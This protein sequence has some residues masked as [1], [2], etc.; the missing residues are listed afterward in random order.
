MRPATR[1]RSRKWIGSLLARAAWLAACVASTTLRAQTLPGRLSGAGIVVGLEYSLLDN[2]RLSNSLADAF[3]VTGLTGMKH[4]VESVQ[5]G[6]MQKNATAPIDFSKL[7]WFVRGYQSRGFTELTI[8]LKPHSEWASKSVGKLKSTNAAP[9]PE[10][11][12]LFQT[13]VAAV[14]E[15]YDHDGVNDMNGL[16]W[17]VRLVEIGN[18]FSSY[19]PEPADEYLDVLRMAYQAAHRASSTVLVGHAAFLTTP[20]NLDVSDPLEYD[21]RWRATKREDRAHDLDDIRKILDHPELFD[22]VNLHN[23]GDPYEIEHQV[24]WVKFETSRRGYTKPIVIS[25]T[26]PTSYVGWGAATACTGLGLGLIVPPAKESDRCRLAAYFTKLVNKDAATLDWTRGFVA[27]DHVQ[28]TVIAAEQG[29][30]AINLSF[31]ADLP[32]LTTP[33]LRAGAGI[34]AW[35]GALAYNAFG[36]AIV[37]RYPLFYAVKQLMEQL[38]GYRSITRV[39]MADARARVYRVDNAAGVTWIAWRDPKGVLLPEDGKPTLSVTLPVGMARARVQE[40]ITATG[41]TLAT[42]TVMQTASGQLTLQLSHTPVY[43]RG[44]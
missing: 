7:D 36:G 3:A 17:P 16:R 32:F 5:W 39:P 12:D 29:I 34:S 44:M 27:A 31:V 24:K 26:L 13:W 41:Q 11:R 8:S 15:R 18:E 4:Y 25:D 23:L 38:T 9:K 33:A 6:A 19:E 1:S 28:R 30:L 14:V 10:Y 40:V 43:V 37:Q 42:P 2:E 20:V 35:G 22:F 21:A